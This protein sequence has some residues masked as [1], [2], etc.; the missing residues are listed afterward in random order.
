MAR[1][2]LYCLSLCELMPSSLLRLRDM[3]TLMDHC[4]VMVTVALHVIY[5][6]QSENTTWITHCKLC[7]YSF[8]ALQ[9]VMH[10]EYGVSFSVVDDR[11][12]VKSHD[13]GFGYKKIW[14]DMEDWS[15]VRSSVEMWKHGGL[16]VG[17]GGEEGRSEE[18]SRPYLHVG[19]WCQQWVS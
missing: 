8:Y 7:A 19:W 6:F 2:Y 5:V 17:E 13:S 16:E 15:G 3:N 4:H 14:Y 1:F 11:W 12:Q 18:V 9:C 10:V